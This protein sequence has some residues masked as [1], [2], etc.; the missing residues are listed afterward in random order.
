MSTYLVRRIGQSLLLIPLVWFVIYT[1]LVYMMPLG[2]KS[3][4]QPG[5]PPNLVF[6][7]GGVPADNQ[8]VRVLDKPWPFSF[9]VWLFDPGNTTETLVDGK[10]VPKGIN[11]GIGEVRL[12]G[13]GMLTGDFGLSTRAAKGRKVADAISERWPNTAT[14]IGLSLLVALLFAV[15]L[16]IFAAVRSRSWVDQA[17]TFFSFAGFSLPP[18]SLGMLLIMIFAL[19]PYLLHV[20]NN[21]SWLPYLPPGEISSM[22]QE[23][24]F[25]DRLQH[26]ILPVATLS[27]PQIAWLSRHVRFSMLEILKLDYIRTAWAKGLPRRRVVFKHAFRNALIPVITSI[28]LA[29]PVLIS[30]AIMVET[31]FG[32][33]GL[34]Q[35]FFAG[36]GGEVSPLQD[37]E[38]GR[39]G[40]LDYPVTLALMFIVVVVVAIANLLADILYTAADPRISY[41]TKQS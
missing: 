19:G 2:P 38:P 32:F 39:I 15:P 9:F 20:T 30:S 8:L 11:I 4:Y 14:L 37:A 34:G 29:V 23:N 7:G 12:Q 17:L 13:A 27:I 26:L 5:M 33:P 10:V 18:F 28:G 22:G 1:V 24:N 21:W 31:V 36:L 41:S 40:L 25:A 16:G 35:I 3:L 6:E